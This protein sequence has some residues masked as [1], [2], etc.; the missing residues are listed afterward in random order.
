MDMTK[1]F[2][3]LC[4]GCVVV[5]LLL[6]CGCD[7]SQ[8]SEGNPLCPGSRNLTQAL[9]VISANQNIKPIKASGR[10]KISWFEDGK[11]K[12]ET[13]N[14]RLRFVPPYNIYFAGSILGQ[15]SFRLGLNDNQFWYRVKPT[16]EFYYGDRLNAYKCRDNELINPA[17]LLEAI[18][19]VSVDNTWK[20]TKTPV[21]DVLTK[22]SE[23][24][25]PVKKIFVNQCSGR[26]VRVQYFDKTGSPVMTLLLG[27]YVT[28][29]GLTV[30]SKIDM[31]SHDTDGISLEIDLRGVSLFEPTAKQLNGKL[32]RMPSMDGY[33]KVYELNNR[34]KFVRK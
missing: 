18:G 30:P 20:F 34:C 27:D 5:V 23:N 22:V 29:D 9:A 21:E 2:R 11:I 33:E 12:D 24:G 13:P 15:E 31:M 19:I 8:R 14:V 32:F 6:F 10:C 25:R 16:S 26:I 1:T 7:S 4:F 3:V 28:T 17:T